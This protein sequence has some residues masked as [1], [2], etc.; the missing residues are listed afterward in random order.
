[1]ADPSQPPYRVRTIVVRFDP[2][3]TE[4]IPVG[5][6]R[7]GKEAFDV[8]VGEFPQPVDW[9]TEGEIRNLLRIAAE[10]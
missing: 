6:V 2:E 5:I 9:Y 7:R 1:M 4:D 10:A 8:F 3:S